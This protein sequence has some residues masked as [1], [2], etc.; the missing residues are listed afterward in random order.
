MERSSSGMLSL[1]RKILLTRFLDWKI[2]LMLHWGSVLLKQ[3]FNLDLKFKENWPKKRITI[4]TS[5][6]GTVIKILLGT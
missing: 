4:K 6:L 5:F 3:L 2:T 1:N